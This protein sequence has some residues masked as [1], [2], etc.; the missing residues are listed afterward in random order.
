MFCMVEI[1]LFSWEDNF[2]SIH[3]LNPKIS[4]VA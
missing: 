3:K 2:P 4:L 1:E